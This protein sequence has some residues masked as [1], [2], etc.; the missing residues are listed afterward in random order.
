MLPCGLYSLRLL[1]DEQ[2]VAV[3]TEK[4]QLMVSSTMV[5]IIIYIHCPLQDCTDRPMTVI[6][7]N[8]TANRCMMLVAVTLL[9]DHSTALAVF[10]HSRFM[11]ILLYNN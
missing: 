3:K 1:V 7:I 9:L 8:L 10:I 11:F 5:F 2:I 4:M 6:T